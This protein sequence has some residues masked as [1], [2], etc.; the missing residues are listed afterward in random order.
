[1]TWGE[2]G[3]IVGVD[4]EGTVYVSSDDGQ[5]WH[6]RGSLD[7]SPQAL[8]AT[9]AQEIFAAVEGAILASSDGGRSFTVPYE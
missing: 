1:M 6:R 5:S 7:G 3:T 2:D 9:D 8:T 4:L